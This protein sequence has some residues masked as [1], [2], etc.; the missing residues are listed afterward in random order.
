[1]WNQINV[2]YFPTENCWASAS[3]HSFVNLFL[4]WIHRRVAGTSSVLE[5]CL[6]QCTVLWKVV[7]LTQTSSMSLSYFE[8]KDNTYVCV[9][10]SLSTLIILKVYYIYFHPRYWPVFSFPAKSSHQLFSDSFLLIPHYGPDPPPMGPMSWAAAFS[11]L[12][13]DFLP[14]HCVLLLSHYAFVADEI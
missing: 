7:R 1:M 6:L 14:W 10:G 8:I 5:F 11:R 13:S 12:T 3:C 9:C 4:L 2:I